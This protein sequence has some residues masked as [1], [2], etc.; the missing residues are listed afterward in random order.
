MGTLE[1]GVAVK[2]PLAPATRAD[3]SADNFP[4][5]IVGK[6]GTETA[7]IVKEFAA[8]VEMPSEVS[9]LVGA[10]T[11]SSHTPGELQKK[12]TAPYYA[13]S[14]D[15]IITQGIITQTNVI[16]KMQNSRIQMNYNNDFLAAFST[17]S[18]TLDDG[19][20]AVLHYDNTDKN[21]APTFWL[22]GEKTASLTVNFTGVTTSGVTKTE[23]RVYTKEQAAEKYDN[24]SEFFTGGDALIINMG[25]ITSGSGAV[26]D[27]DINV[28]IIFED[29]TEEV[30]IPVDWDKTDPKPGEDGPSLIL[31]ADA[32]YSEDG[33]GM[34]ESADALISA[35]A[36][37]ESIVVKIVAGNEGFQEIMEDLK[38]DGQSFLTGINLIDNADFHALMSGVDESLSAPHNGDTQYTFPL[39][40]FFTFLNITGATD[41]GKA[42]EFHI[43]VT[44]KDGKTATGIYKVTITETE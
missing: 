17:W 37:L 5:K 33:T 28:N 40:V 12:M 24:D 11:V 42:H 14:N 1:L 21:P 29:H 22:F 30:E 4:V 20:E 6:E 15:L 2:A 27:I 19:S 35:E 26:K 16:C 3:V 13:G 34:P 41:T 23:R 25:S 43:V 9:L 31:P 8:F 36:G 39:G 44:D 10:Y 18:I 7:S 32:I 38:M